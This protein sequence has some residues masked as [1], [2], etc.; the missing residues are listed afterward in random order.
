MDLRGDDVASA[1]AL[2]EICGDVPGDDACGG[3]GDVARSSF[4]G[5][6]GALCFSLC[7]ALFFVEKQTNLYSAKKKKN[8]SS[9]TLESR[10]RRALASRRALRSALV[11][12]LC[13]A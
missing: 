13:R 1:L 8:H 12:E 11:S 3:G 9:D 7:S 4:G 5:G 2:G 6:S 10:L